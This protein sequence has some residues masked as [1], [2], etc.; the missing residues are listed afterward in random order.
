MTSSRAEAA[1]YALATRASPRQWALTESRWLRFGSFSAF[2]F[3]Q[4]VP[5]GLLYIAIP[6][7]LAEHGASQGEIGT[8]T[9][10]VGL[11][12]A[13]KLIAGPFMD[14]FTFLPMGFRRPWVIALQGGL[15]L[16]LLVLAAVGYGFE[17]G[18]GGGSLAALTA[19]G[20]LVNTFAAT[21]DVAVDGMAIDVL[22]ENERGRAN[23]FMGFGQSAARSAFGAL[24]GT[25]LALGGIA[26]GAF[27]CAIAVAA[28]FVLAAV[29]RERPGERRLPWGEGVAAPRQQAPPTMLANMGSVARALVLP[30]SL[31]AIAVEFVS[32]IRD[33]MA[34]ALFPVLATQGLGLSAE[35]FSW[36]QGVA[37]FGA[38]TLAVCLG[39][40]ID[41]FGAK[42]LLL[43]SLFASAAVH[44]VAGLAPG[45]WQDTTVLAVVFFLSEALT[46]LVFVCVIALF[47]NLCWQPVAA[48]QF[49][50]YMALANLG[51]SAGAAVLALIEGRLDDAQLLLAMAGLLGAAGLLLLLFNE[52]AH[53]RQLGRLDERLTGSKPKGSA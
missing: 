38:A 49:A 40:A 16:S 37:A 18:P 47:M 22:P 21:Q 4:G 41:A 51:R 34:T 45:L 23:A 1:G 29:L 53:K 35:L 2:Y 36:I 8:Y 42:R 32:R 6:N 44:L 50:V 12:W 33:G 30:M 9:A 20:A 5:L 31:V 17:A 11:P 46:Q 15:V 13:L 3:A 48:T 28:V 25:L 43:L 19:A 39:P 7:W 26:A 24:C 52:E 10:L 27:A 14:R